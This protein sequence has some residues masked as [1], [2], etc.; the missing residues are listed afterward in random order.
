MDGVIVITGVSRGLGYAVARGLI[1]EG[2]AV[3]GCCRGHEAASRLSGEFGPL[4]RFAAVDVA[5]DRSV[6][7]WARDLLGDGEAPDMLINNAAI[8]NGNGPLWEVP[9][10]EFSRLMDINIKGTY[11]VIRHFLPAM[12]SRR[13]GVLVN[14]SSTWGRTTSPQVAPYCAS[15]W[16][17][18]GLTRALAKELPRGLA[19][20]ALNPGVIGTDMLR[21]CFGESAA[22]YPSPAEWAERAVPFLLELGPQHNG[23]SL[24]V[25]E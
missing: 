13:Q 1:A 14:M 24:T 19:A 17:I 6:A 15:K 23:Q 3:A 25:P 10:D 11:H 4:H 8:I 5:D 7:A 20:V 16:A 21:V 18:E 9:P 2:Y 12:I 22:S